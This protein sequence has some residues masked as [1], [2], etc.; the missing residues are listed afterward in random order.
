MALEMLT[1]W[2]RRNNVSEQSAKKKAQR[3]GFKTAIKSGKF[4]LIDS[5]EKPTD[6]RI[7]NGKYIDFRKKSSHSND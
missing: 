3:G 7:K 4:W 1:E 2:A 6:N 5:E